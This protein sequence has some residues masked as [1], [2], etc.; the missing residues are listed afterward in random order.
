MGV[1]PRSAHAEEREH[2][3]TGQLGTLTAQLK[4]M[5]TFV[6]MN[7]KRGQLVCLCVFSQACE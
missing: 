6:V 1:L 5:V 2:K 4:L 3:Q 7:L